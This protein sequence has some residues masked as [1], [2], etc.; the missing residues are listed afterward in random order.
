MF[1]IPHWIGFLHETQK[2]LKSPFCSTWNVTHRTMSDSVAT[3]NAACANVFSTVSSV[4]L[5]TEKI[6]G[7]QTKFNSTLRNWR[8]VRITQ[9]K[10]S[11]PLRS[12][13]SYE[14]VIHKTEATKSSNIILWSCLHFALLSTVNVSILKSQVYL[15][16]C[17][18]EA[19]ET[20]S[21]SM[22]P[23]THISAGQQ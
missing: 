11:S 20:H 19:L 1:I 18:K 14:A 9:N 13:K 2:Q 5:L 3:R 4:C 12:S 22:A 23:S 15:F 21:L 6:W 10:F 17:M 7:T 16:R 8:P